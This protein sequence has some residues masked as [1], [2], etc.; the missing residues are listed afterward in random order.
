MKNLEKK[1]TLLQSAELATCLQI[2][3]FCLV[4]AQQNLVKGNFHFN[5]WL[6]SLEFFY[7]FLFLLVFVKIAKEFIFEVSEVKLQHKPQNRQL[8]DS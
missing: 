4:K 5:R 8:K 3:L 2:M 1:N 7:K 6:V